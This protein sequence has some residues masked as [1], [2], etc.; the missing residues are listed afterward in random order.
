MFITLKLFEQ[1][2]LNVCMVMTL[3]TENGD[4]LK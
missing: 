3:S 2:W 4:T 1:S